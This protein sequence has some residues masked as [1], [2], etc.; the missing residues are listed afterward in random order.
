M[1]PKYYLVCNG[2]L[3]SIGISKKLKL[4]VLKLRKLLQRR[5]KCGLHCK[6]RDQGGKT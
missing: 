6:E 1:P 5:S 3:Q 4:E 2:K